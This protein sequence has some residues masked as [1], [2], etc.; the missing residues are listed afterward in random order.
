VV[1]NFAD[2]RSVDNQ[3]AAE[4]ARRAGIQALL[5]AIWS[6]TRGH[7]NPRLLGDQELYDNAG[8][9]RECRKDARNVNP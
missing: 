7:R 9:Y 3:D 5:Q 4:T 6:E 1:R 8:L 2:E